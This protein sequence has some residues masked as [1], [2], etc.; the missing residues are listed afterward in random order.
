MVPSMRNG[1]YIG[2]KNG[3]LTVVRE[4]EKKGKSRHRRFECECHSPHHLETRIAIVWASNLRSQQSCGCARSTRDGLSNHKLYD[5]WLTMIDRCYDHGSEAYPH[6]G[7]RGIAVCE[8]WRDKKDGCKSFIAWVESLPPGKQ[9]EQGL[10]IDRE[11]NNGNYCPDNC[12]FVTRSIN[13]RNRRQSI[14]VD[15]NGE[16]ILLVEAWEK[17]G[18][19][20]LRYGTVVNRYTS[21]WSV[22][23]A[24]NKEKQHA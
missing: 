11:D 5:L 20:S 9:W 23:D 24:I 21:G 2:R 19:R 1:D 13:V 8:A 12:R 6:Y 22:H 18:N 14:W 7:G 10:D 16:R 3:Y 17:Y 15:F 4:V